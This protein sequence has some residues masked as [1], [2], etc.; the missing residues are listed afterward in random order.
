MFDLVVRDVQ[1]WQ[2]GTHRRADIAVV[3]G[4]VAAIAPELD[5][6]GASELHGRGHLAIPG[7]VE[8]H[9]H[10]DKSRL[11]GTGIPP[12]ADL[13]DAIARTAEAKALFTPEDVHARASATLR[14]C[15][16]H[17]TTHIRTHVEVDP[18]VELRGLDGVLAAAEDFSWA[19][20]VEVCVFPQEGLAL[21]PDTEKL[22]I[23]GLNRGA[24]AIG[25][26][27][28]TDT[29]PRAQIDRIFELARLF[30]VDID[31]HLDFAEHAEEMQVEYVCTKTDE[32]GYGGRVT[33]GHLTQLSYLPP[34]EV[35]RV[36]VRLADAGVAVTALPSTDL[37]LMGRTQS[38]AKAR[39]VAPLAPLRERGVVCSLATNN[40]LNSFTPY[41]NGSL[42]HMA[43]LYANVAHVSDAAELAD[44][45][46][47]ITYD[48]ARIAGAAGYGFAVGSRAD[49]VLLDTDSAAGAVR[50]IA[51]P[52]WALRGGELT[53]TRPQAELHHPTPNPSIRTV[54]P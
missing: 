13:D 49:L 42:L 11:I 38:H 41:G 31:M 39:G 47:M 54:T 6:P 44:C 48:A 51:E 5:A 18:A 2:D 19:I 12:A 32:F 14:E 40:V 46:G 3:D 30:D 4:R 17:G 29:D 26:A 1:L 37:F 53:F 9:L 21:S 24:T 28:Y 16:L 34:E 36:A 20:D 27:P 43:N 10:L 35:D 23:A 25:G 52:L 45:L 33:V 50:E 15:V 7:F 22:L 8:T